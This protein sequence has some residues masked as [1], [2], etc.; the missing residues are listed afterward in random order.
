MNR[1]TKHEVSMLTHDKGKMKKIGVVLGV[2][3]YK[4]IGKIIIRYSTYDFLS[5]FNRNYV[6]ILYRFRVIAVIRRK[7]LV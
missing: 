5:N 2:A 7:W 4:V 1:Y 6:S 3:Y